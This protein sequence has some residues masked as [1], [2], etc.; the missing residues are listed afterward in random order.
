MKS[1]K[2]DTFIYGIWI[3]LLIVYF[4]M[5]FIAAAV[6]ILASFPN[7]GFPCYF[8]AVVNYSALNLSEYNVMNH[9]TPTLYLEPP[10]MFTYMFISFMSDC[11][12]AIYYVCAAVAMYLAKKQVSGLTD[13]SSWINSVGS[14][15]ALFLCILK[16][17][18]IQ[19]FIQILAYKH[20]FLSAFIY[21]LHFVSSVIYATVC[22]TRMSPIW[23][24]KTQDSSI[25]RNTL[26]W[27]VVFQFKP[28]ATNFCMLCLAL[29]TLV[30]SLS[31]C[32]AIGNSFYVM[33]ADVVLAAINLF[34]LLPLIW[35]IITEVWL[36]KFFPHP[37]GFY[38]GTLIGSI[39]LALPLI[40]YESIFVSAKLHSTIAANIS[41]IPIL[42]S[43]ALM[44]RV[45]R[46]FLK[47]KDTE[48]SP[49]NDDIPMDNKVQ[50]TTRSKMQKKSRLAFGMQQSS[51]ALLELVDSEDELYP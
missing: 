42:G 34:V 11:V 14:P 17:W 23:I 22:I 31:I 21:F 25:P 6:P 41:I 4:V 36:H 43:I 13:L 9:I 1:S 27:R 46:S 16:M 44:I 49:L 7:L 19:T 35:Y 18:S 26:L 29:E 45:V 3:K 50:K 15:T 39:I 38:I 24:I 37:Y 48:Y 47:N 30:F 33:V 5:F 2:N 51:P 32:L 12:S 8:N 20:L 28:I 40:R 10:E